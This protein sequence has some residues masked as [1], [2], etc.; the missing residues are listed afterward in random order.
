MIASV[1]NKLFK[2]LKA[3]TTKK[4]IREQQ[5]SLLAGKKL[6]TEY[7]H[8]NKGNH[9]FFWIKEKHH[10][11]PMGD[12]QNTVTLSKG[13]FSLLDESGSHAP[14]LSLPVPQIFPEQSSEKSLNPKLPTLYLSLGDPNNMGA[15]LR[16]AKAFGILQIVLLKEACLP[17]LPKALR[18][19]SGYALDFTYFQ[20]PSIQ[21]LTGE[22]I[23]GLD[24]AGTPLDQSTLP[25][26]FHLLVGQEGQGL[27]SSF[28][29][30]RLAIAM[31]PGV[32]SLNAAVTVGICL[33]HWQ[34]QVES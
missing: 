4:G 2:S 16:S 24:M 7:I 11:L 31:A 19:S 9:D 29:G 25:R 27:P 3:L 22:S 5:R 14:L 12:F 34:S 32:E 6:C 20:G 26:N 10:A 1:D 8:K 17:F 23:H 28:S 18:T 21:D 33:H 15:V 13:L 30:P